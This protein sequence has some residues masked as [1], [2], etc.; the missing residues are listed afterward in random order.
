MT[1]NN[2]KWY[3]DYQLFWLWLF[4][5]PLCETIDEVMCFIRKKGNTQNSAQSLHNRDMTSNREAVDSREEE[6]DSLKYERYTT[7]DTH[8]QDETS[9]ATLNYTFMFFSSCLIEGWRGYERV[10]MERVSIKELLYAKVA[11][12]CFPVGMK[13]FYFRENCPEP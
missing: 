2:M 11:F 10:A 7:S 8:R 1:C 6:C 12:I 4:I 9:Y 3:A 13:C 5:Q